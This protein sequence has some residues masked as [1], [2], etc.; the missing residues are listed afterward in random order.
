MNA[1]G[2]MASRRRSLGQP[3]VFIMNLVAD[4]WKRAYENAL[5]YELRKQ[6]LD[7]RQQFPVNVQYDGTIVGEYF[8]DLMIDGKVSSNLR[9]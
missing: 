1:E 8:A 2:W 4:S 5:A 7:V 6:N 3:I 9:R